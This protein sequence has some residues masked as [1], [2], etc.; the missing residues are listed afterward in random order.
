M[1]T[2]PTADPIYHDPSPG[3]TRTRRSSSRR[4]VASSLSRSTS[5]LGSPR[6]IC[7]KDGDAFSYDPAHL[8][9]WF[10]PQDLWDRMPAA[11]QSSVAAVQHSGAAVLTGF[12]RL[13]RHTEALD[14]GRPDLQVP[15]DELAVELDDLPVQKFRSISNASSVF[16]TDSST[17][18]TAA[19]PVSRSGSAS[20]VLSSFSQSQTMSPLSPVSLGPAA[21]PFDKQLRSRERSFSTPL[22]SRDAHYVLELSHLRTEALPRLRHLGHKVDTEWYEAKRSG[23]VSAEDANAFENWWAEKKC[24]ILTL[25]ETGKRLATASGLQPTGMGWTAP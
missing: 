25:S 21:E 12:A 19:S 20:P 3:R 5:N 8:R 13:D 23:A 17:S 10:L 11:L 2:S 9:N 14:G 1:A 6:A 16:F 22:E 24:A 4:S 18:T 15:A 7:P